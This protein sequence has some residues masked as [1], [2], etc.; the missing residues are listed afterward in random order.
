MMVIPREKGLVRL[1]IQLT[2]VKPDESGRADR[3]QISPDSILKAA[4]KILHPYK[5]EYNY[6]DWWTGYQIGQRVGNKFSDQERIFL[7]GDA[8]HTHSPKAGQGM[9]VSMQDT[10]N[11]G[12][13]LGLVLKGV[14]D[15]SILR[16]YQDERRGIAKDLI[17]F[18]HKFSRLFSGRPAKDAADDTGVNM[19][20]F[21]AVYMKGHE[22]ASG[23][24]V[25]YGGSPL[26]AK[27]SDNPSSGVEGKQYLAT[28]ILLGKRFPSYQVL[29]QSDARPWPLQH[30]LAATGAFYI[31]IFAGAVASQP[32]LARLKACCTDLEELLS[33]FPVGAIELLTV[34]SSP[35][36]SLERGIFDL[37]ALLRQRQPGKGEDAGKLGWDYNRIFADE[38][39]YHSGDGKAYEGYGVDK[40]RG[41]LV[42]CRPDQYVSYTGELE[43]VDEVGR[44]FGGF[45]RAREKVE[46][47]GEKKKAKVEVAEERQG[48]K[49]ANREGGKELTGLEMDQAAGLAE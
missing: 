38:A 12:W 37:P 14:C 13:K 19:A 27:A 10:F 22:F 32:Q 33:R 41:C 40:E 20:E 2:E 5:L 18:D 25:N 49:Q 34:H 21:K 8:I 48:F 31:V 9:N 4:Q 39:S 6:C 45:M 29:N 24:S 36:A 43:D 42:V 46:S 16:T 1:Y 26:V 47:V 15:R 44:F 23:I 3:S 7:A 11:L 30:F 28:S 35:R 17:A